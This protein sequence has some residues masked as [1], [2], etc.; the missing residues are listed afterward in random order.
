VGSLKQSATLF[1]REQLNSRVQTQ[2]VTK[3]PCICNSA[4]RLDVFRCP[5]RCIVAGCSGQRV[6]VRNSK[7]NHDD[8][9]VEKGPPNSHQRTWLSS[10]VLWDRRTTGKTGKQSPDDTRALNSRCMRVYASVLHHPAG[11]PLLQEPCL[12]CLLNTAY[13]FTMAVLERVAGMV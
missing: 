4:R 10:M 7:P 13:V 12:L 8:S 1:V 5:V 3:Q 2:L 6:E 11:C 9:I